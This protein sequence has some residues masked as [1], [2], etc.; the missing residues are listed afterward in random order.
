MS[1]RSLLEFHGSIILL[2]LMDDIM[3]QQAAGYNN[4]LRVLPAA[5]HSMKFIQ[6]P[7]RS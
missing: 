3:H 6:L 5:A 4:N 2:V 7:C 1:C